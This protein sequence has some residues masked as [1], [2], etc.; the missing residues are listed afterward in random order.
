[1]KRGMEREMKSRAETEDKKRH[2]ITEQDKN[3]AEQN[4]T[5]RNRIENRIG[6]DRARQYMQGQ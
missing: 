6:W 3:R 5:E 2:D 1:V 4:M